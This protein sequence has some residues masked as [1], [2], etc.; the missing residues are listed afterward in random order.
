V[1]ADLV[2]DIRDYAAMVKDLPSYDEQEE[3]L[4]LFIRREV[5]QDALRA[6]GT[7]PA[8]ELRRL[9]TA[10]ALLTKHRPRLAKRFPELF[11]PKPDLPREYWWWYLDEEPRPVATVHSA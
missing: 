5:I 9:A 1:P 2:S 7:P 4:N 10:D 3:V 6:G 8:A 11:E